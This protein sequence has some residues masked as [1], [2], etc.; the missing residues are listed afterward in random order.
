MEWL[1][2]GYSIKFADL[3]NT[4][5][6]QLNFFFLKPMDHV[7]KVEKNHDHAFAV[8]VNKYGT[9]THVI[10]L[11]QMFITGSEG[12]PFIGTVD[13]YIKYINQKVPGHYVISEI[14]YDDIHRVDD[15][16]DF[17]NIVS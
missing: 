2:V 1:Q 10:D 5:K 9:I 11:W 3:D 12:Q 14:S 7:P 8:I 13:D 17:T 15:P 6:S 4:S 16:V